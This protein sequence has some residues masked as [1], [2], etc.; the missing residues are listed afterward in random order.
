MTA[1]GGSL[2]RLLSFHLMLYYIISTLSVST[3][4][5]LENVNPSP[6][7]AHTISCVVQKTKEKRKRDHSSLIDAETRAK[8]PQNTDFC[9]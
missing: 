5:E 3:D 6:V 4:S 2:L 7:R 1:R 8:Q 9:A